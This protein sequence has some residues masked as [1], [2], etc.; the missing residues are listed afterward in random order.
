MSVVEGNVRTR[1]VDGSIKTYSNDDIF[2]A[3]PE[4]PLHSL[5]DKD[6]DIA[7]RPWEEKEEN[8]KYKEEKKLDPSD[9]LLFGDEGDDSGE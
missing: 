2:L 9:E 6:I 7:Y 8:M 3:G 4:A 5:T 1:L